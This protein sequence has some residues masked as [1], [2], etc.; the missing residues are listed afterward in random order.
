VQ[1]NVYT[2]WH[3]HSLAVCRAIAEGADLPLVGPEKLLPGGVVTYGF[4]RGLKAILD[5][6]REIGRTWVYADRGYLRA[7]YGDDHSG[8][9]RLTRDAWQHDGS[10][11][12]PET[13]W[14][15]LGLALAP[16]QRGGHVLVC[17]P[18]DV[19]TRAVGGFPA[20]DWER[21]T[22]AALARATDRPIRI[23]RKGGSSTP[24][25]ADLADCHALV[26]YMSNT[27]VEALLAGV[28]VFCTGPCAAA[29]MGKNDLAEIE[30]PA[31]PEDRERW[32]R[33]LAANQFTLAELRAG[34]GNHLF[35]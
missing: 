14:R 23:R 30:S 34:K 15:A 21:D 22:L 9:F 17:P 27:A 2:S 33:V 6:A 29:A 16:W 18:G 4:L 32:A 7:T 31:Y 10:G 13:R 5:A 25:A 26:T 28:P 20:A 8:Y 24:L 3:S 19:F 35:Q 12:A 1:A 11:D